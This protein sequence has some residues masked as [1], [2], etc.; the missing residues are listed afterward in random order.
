MPPHYTHLRNAATS[1]SEREER[2]EKQTGRERESE[3]DKRR[4]ANRERTGDEKWRDTE[5]QTKIAME[6]EK[7]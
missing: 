7:Q 3:R 4:K 5:R 6:E 2:E 1:F